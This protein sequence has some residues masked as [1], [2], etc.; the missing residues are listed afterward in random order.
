M[1]F[2]DILRELLDNHDISQKQ[3][4]KD[5]NNIA[6]STLG[7]YIRNIREPDFETLKQFANYF[8]VSTDYLLDRQ[9]GFTANHLED[10]LLCVFR[11]LPDSQQKM[12]LEQGKVL[13]K[14]LKKVY[15][16]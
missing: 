8:K 14:F 9:T 16:D 12:Y 6:A 3:L 11:S 1:Q 4:A 15:N 2:G 13:L 7:N 5:M 10:E